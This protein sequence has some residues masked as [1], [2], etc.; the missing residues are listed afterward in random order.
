MKEHFWP[1][2]KRDHFWIYH[3]ET[4]KPRAN[5]G[6]TSLDKYFEEAWKEYGNNKEEMNDKSPHENSSLKG[7]STT[8][9]G[10]YKCGRERC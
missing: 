1:K 8:Q 3:Q 4:Q 6:N 7:G 2:M 5:V 10:D 9:G